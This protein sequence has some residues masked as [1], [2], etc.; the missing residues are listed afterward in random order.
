MS[1]IEAAT[2]IATTLL[3]SGGILFVIVKHYIDKKNTETR[4]DIKQH[5]SAEMNS[6]AFAYDIV[7]MDIKKTQVE[8]YLEAICLRFNAQ[9]A[10]VGLFHNGELGS[11]NDHLIKVTAAYEWPEHGINNEH[12]EHMS[13]KGIIKSAYVL[14]LGGWIGKLLKDDWY[15]SRDI[16]IDDALMQAQFNKWGLYENVNALLYFNGKPIGVIGLNWVVKNEKDF[17]QQ[18]GAANHQE[19][20]RKF[21]SAQDG[22]VQTLLA[23]T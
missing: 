20:I 23:K 13:V 18:M 8:R 14:Q 1:L 4:K 12:G 11:N 9:S 2:T 7:R 17:I 16:P 15:C 5:I 21:R 19:A 6:T 3:G 22:L 10:W